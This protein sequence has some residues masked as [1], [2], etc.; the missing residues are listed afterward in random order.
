MLFDTLLSR[1]QLRERIIEQ[2]NFELWTPSEVRYLVYPNSDP[3]L[4][5]SWSQFRSQKSEAQRVSHQIQ[6]GDSQLFFSMT[7]PTALSNIAKE[8]HGDSSDFEC[9]A[10]GQAGV[11]YEAPF[12]LHDIEHCGPHS[13]KEIRN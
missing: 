7:N 6:A 10:V 3:Y 12:T 4:I 11:R 8:D 13:L 2:N 9:A 5:G 1:T